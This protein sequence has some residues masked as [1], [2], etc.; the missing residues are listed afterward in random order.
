MNPES[1]DQVFASWARHM[2]WGEFDQAWEISDN[3]L[4]SPL[5]KLQGHAPRHLQRIWDGSALAGKRVL[6]RCY[7]GL[8]DT[9]QFIRYAPK[10]K[11]IAEEVIVAVQPVL[12]DLV[13][14]VHGI[15]R[16][17]PLGPDNLQAQYDVD[18]EVMELPY[19]FRT[20]LHT[21][22]AEIPYVH[23]DPA[24]LQ[25]GQRLAVGIVWAAG[26]WDKR[27]SIPLPLLAPLSAISGVRLHVMQ[28]GPALAGLGNEFA[29]V[30][31]CD[32]LV[33]VARLMRALDLLISVDSMPAHLA[34]S[35]GVPVWNLLH[36]DA[37]WRWMVR[38][39]DSPWYPTMRLFR[40]EQANA[41]EPVI[42]TVAAE[43]ARFSANFRTRGR[44]Q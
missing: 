34:G 25:K 5:L 4:R 11:A 2:R 13:R 41:W 31:R 32:D 24:P 44:F 42:A 22:P 43:L 28:Q 38:R 6:I 16:L 21:I 1:P 26:D 27:R 29:A 37:D 12:L 15:D 19:V 8:G 18:V 40:Q 30:S 10:I 3:V 14:S 7:H 39:D 20:T 36:A 35:L 33:E 23:V 9:I 17:L